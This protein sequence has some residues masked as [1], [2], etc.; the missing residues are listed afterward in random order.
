[1]LRSGFKPLHGAVDSL[2]LNGFCGD[3]TGPGRTGALLDGV[4]QFVREQNTSAGRVRRELARVEI[5]VVTVGECLSV[6]TPAQGF[7]GGSG[8]DSHST[9]V[10]SETGFHA[11]PRVIGQRTTFSS[12]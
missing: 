10:R 3:R 12:R 2:P 1:A 8:V 11:P 9:E 6:D 4:R 7:G 5:D